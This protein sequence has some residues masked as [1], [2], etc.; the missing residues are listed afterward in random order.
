[1]DTSCPRRCCRP[2]SISCLSSSSIFCSCR[3][4]CNAAFRNSTAFCSAARESSSFSFK[5]S[6]RVSRSDSFSRSVICVLRSICS[7]ACNS[8]DFLFKAFSWAYTAVWRAFRSALCLSSSFCASKYVLSFL[9]CS[10][11][12]RD[13]RF[14]PSI[15]VTPNCSCAI[16]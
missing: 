7:S 1:M 10:T 4:T 11:V 8:P 12:L 16:R 3:S 14:E 2:S 6:S 13:F 9:S 15:N 5:S